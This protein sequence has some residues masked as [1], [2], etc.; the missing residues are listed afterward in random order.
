MTPKKDPSRI[1][2]LDEHKEE[3]IQGSFT[4]LFFKNE[5]VEKLRKVADHYDST[6]RNIVA[7]FADTL[8]R[9]IHKKEVKK[10]GTN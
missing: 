1:I 2:S 3:L 7:Q 5:T 9:K 6:Y 10:H 8:Y 4:P